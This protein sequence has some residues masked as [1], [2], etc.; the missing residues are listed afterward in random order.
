ML[1]LGGWRPLLDLGG[2]EKRHQ[3]TGQSGPVI[4][5][6]LGSKAQTQT[7]ECNRPS[8]PGARPRSEVAI[9]NASLGGVFASPSSPATFCRAPLLRHCS[10]IAK[11]LGVLASIYRGNPQLL[12][13]LHRRWSFKRIH[14]AL[15]ASIRS[16]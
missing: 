13:V 1:F 3:G 2:P 5:I 8:P 12:L 11:T 4:N 9:N 14:R 7:R 6:L 10:A 16:R 15:R